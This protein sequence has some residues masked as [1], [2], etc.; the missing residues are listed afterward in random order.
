MAPNSESIDRLQFGPISPQNK[1]PTE[2]SPLH[3]IVVAGAGLP[4]PLRG[5]VSLG[6]Y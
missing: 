5:S 3:F 2:A 6:A 4:S 1:G